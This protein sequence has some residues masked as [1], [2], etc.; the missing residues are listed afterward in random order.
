M[1]KIFLTTFLLL[2]LVFVGCGKNT[3]EKQ[4]TETEH[5]VDPSWQ[6]FEGD[7]LV[8]LSFDYPENW[9]TE[10]I[11]GTDGIGG[12]LDVVN[13]DKSTNF[14]LEL[15]YL[16]EFSEVSMEEVMADTPNEPGKSYFIQLD[17]DFYVMAKLDTKNPDHIKTVEKIM[18]TIQL[19]K[20]KFKNESFG[21]SIEFKPDYLT[22]KYNLENPVKFSRWSINSDDFF[23][24][25]VIEGQKITNYQT[26]QPDKTIEINDMETD[27][28]SFPNGYCDANCN[29]QEDEYSNACLVHCSTTSRITTIRYQNGKN[30]LIEFNNTKE[31]TED[32]QEILESF[33]FST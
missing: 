32:K 24:I 27:I 31:L 11:F 14:H 2:S 5:L 33:E 13:Q 22:T 29:K 30:Y 21:Y 17:D 6:T 26:Q 12:A 18:K 1:K 28:Y 25:D 23:V 8:H 19:Q 3:T 20:T 4:S 7:K 9:H 10:N 16:N 15:A